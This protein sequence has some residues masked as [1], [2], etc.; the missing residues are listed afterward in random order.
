[1]R[2]NSPE[3]LHLYM[4]SMYAPQHATRGP[5]KYIHNLVTQFGVR[6]EVAGILVDCGELET[7]GDV[8]PVTFGPKTTVYGYDAD[9]RMAGKPSPLPT[10]QIR[11]W[12]ECAMGQRFLLNLADDHADGISLTHAVTMYPRLL[13]AARHLQRQNNV[14]F[15]VSPRGS[16][17]P[18]HNADYRYEDTGWWM[19]MLK[20]AAYVT[21]NSTQ[22]KKELMDAGARPQNIV[23]IPNGVDGELFT[24]LAPEREKRA[25]IEAVYA[26]RLVP[27]KRVHCVVL[28]IRQAI[29]EGID[30]RLDIHGYGAE[31]A[32]IQALIQKYDLQNR[33]TCT[34]EP[35]EPAQLPQLVRNA[36]LYLTASETE[37]TPNA[38]LEA[39]SLGLAV[40]TSKEAGGYDLFPADYPFLID[41]Q[42][43]TEG[44]LDVLRLAHLRPDV[45]R[46][47]RA[48]CSRQAASFTWAKT[49]DAYI[50]LYREMT[51]PKPV[52]AD[53]E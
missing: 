26:G 6:E 41:N 40:A 39:M 8:P 32:A 28:G 25:A 2:T 3:G 34:G 4:P 48:F 11:Q 31:S 52:R 49:A 1:M 46:E 14:P 42:Q 17:I 19:A 22:L 15:L 30:V 29:Q 20:H 45:L 36:D 23:V 27:F 9:T 13:I 7:Q 47:Q 18:L 33:I 5:E 16:D 24:P 12:S 43:P 21:P 38:T 51:R 50:N 10:K 53:G 37:G 35:Y 44:I